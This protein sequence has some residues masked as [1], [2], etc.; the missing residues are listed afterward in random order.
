MRVTVQK[1][2]ILPVL[3]R[4]QGIAGRKTNLAIT[5]NLLIRTTDSGVAFCATD[6]ETGFEGYYPAV[7]ESKGSVA[8]NARKFLRLPEIFQVMKLF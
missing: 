4:I 6:L 5:T 3:S 1:A 7:V 2:V 8:I